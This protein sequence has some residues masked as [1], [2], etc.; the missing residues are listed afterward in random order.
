MHGRE[1]ASQGRVE[2]LIDGL[3]ELGYVPN[4]NYRVDVRDRDNVVERLPVLARE[5]L[6]Q[7]PD[8]TV[9]SPV[10]SAQALR[11]ESMTVPR[12]C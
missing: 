5:I 2:S 3:R 1:S 8:V 7:K 4:R 9:A 6:A 10:L 12:F 11:R